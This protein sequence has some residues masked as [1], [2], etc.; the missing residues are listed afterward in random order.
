M[1]YK[2]R[3]DIFI[4]N[5]TFVINFIGIRNFMNNYIIIRLCFL[6]VNKYYVVGISSYIVKMRILRLWEVKLF[7][8]VIMIVGV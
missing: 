6:E 8:R 2:C 3:L 5:V 4:I 1:E 7:F